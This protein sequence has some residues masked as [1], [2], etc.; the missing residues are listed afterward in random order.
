MLPLKPTTAIDF[1]LTLFWADSFD[2]TVEAQCAGGAINI[3]DLMAF[4]EVT[5]RTEN[6][7]NKVN[8]AKSK[9]SVIVEETPDKQLKVNVK[10]E[11]NS[12]V[13]C[14]HNNKEYTVLSSQF[15]KTFYVADIK[16]SVFSLF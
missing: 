11:P 12:A 5:D 9:R 15:G 2:M 7:S 8:V 14:A 1:V 10:K 6:I 4:Q 13:N 16:V 3:T